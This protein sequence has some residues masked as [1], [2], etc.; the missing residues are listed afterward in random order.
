MKTFSA[1]SRTIRFVDSVEDG[2]LVLKV[3]EQKA[4]Q[5]VNPRIFT[6]LKRF[7]VLFLV[8]RFFAREK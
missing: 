3:Y 8:S 7:L 2:A 6:K 1:A 4:G 5:F